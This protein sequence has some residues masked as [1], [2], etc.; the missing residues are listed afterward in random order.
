[1][2][3]KSPFGHMLREFWPL[4]ILCA[5]LTVLVIGI[6]AIDDTITKFVPKLASKLASALFWG[7]VAVIPTTKW[8]KW[9]TGELA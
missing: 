7:K 6:Q 8:H 2:E 1:M 4:V 5:G 3:P 9:L